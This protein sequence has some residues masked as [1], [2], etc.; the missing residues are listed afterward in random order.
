MAVLFGLG[1]SLTLSAYGAFTALIGQYLGLDQLTRIMFAIAGTAAFLFGLS[2]LK[3]VAFTLPGFSGA[4]P[5]WMQQ[6][7]DYLRVLL[8]GLFLGNA[9][10]GCPNPAFYV[11]LG[12]IA[13]VGDI[14]T[15]WLLGLV[16]GIGRATPLILLAILGMVGVNVTGLLVSKKKLVDSIMGWALVAIGSFILTYGSFGMPW[17]EGS[18]FHASWNQLVYI[19]APQLA[20]APS[21]PVT[22]GLFVVPFWAGWVLFPGLVG[23]P[24]VWATIK[25]L[26]S[27]TKAVLIVS[28]ILVFMLLAATETIKAEYEHGVDD[29]PGRGVGM[30]NLAE[31]S[32]NL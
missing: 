4:I 31:R 2:E 26:L 19:I 20:E 10:V 24:V 8:M 32:D 16:H 29:V 9:G 21:H 7:Q 18:V 6:R 15:G 28:I 12:Y 14:G 22:K 27:K 13:T 11:L 3:L 25:K 17:W 30:L 5:T 1:V 23:V